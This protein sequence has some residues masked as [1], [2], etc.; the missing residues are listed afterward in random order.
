M[1]NPRW[2]CRYAV[3]R[4]WH[5]SNDFRGWISTKLPIIHFSTDHNSNSFLKF[6]IELTS[7]GKQETTNRGLWC[8]CIPKTSVLKVSI[9]VLLK[10]TGKWPLE[11]QTLRLESWASILETFEDQVSS[12]EDQVLRI[13]KQG[14]LEYAK[15][16]GFRGNNL[17]LKGRI[18]QYCSHLKF[19]CF[20]SIVIVWTHLPIQ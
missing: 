14:F 18:I 3:W 4:S 19:K 15:T 10:S 6:K 16:R 8:T 1:K 2:Q 17:F 11:T 7:N 5:L 9:T 20:A 12:L 13:E